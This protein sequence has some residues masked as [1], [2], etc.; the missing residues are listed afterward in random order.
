MCK[1]EPNAVCL[2]TFDIDT[3]LP[4]RS[5]AST[6]QASVSSKDKIREFWEV[7]VDGFRDPTNH[8]ECIKPYYQP[9]LVVFLPSCYFSSRLVL[10][11]NW[12]ASPWPAEKSHQISH[13]QNMIDLDKGSLSEPH[14]HGS[15]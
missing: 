5:A 13:F 4:N 7:F 11:E 1:V 14:F 8:L 15:L 12:Q 10:R 3:R 9:Q 6:Q 2:E